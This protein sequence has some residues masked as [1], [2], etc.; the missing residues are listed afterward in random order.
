ML[1]IVTDG[2]LAIDVETDGDYS[3]MLERS[4]VQ[5]RFADDVGRV[6]RTCGRWKAYLE[7]GGK[8]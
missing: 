8:L 4:I 3:T 1:S 5:N 2:S 7:V 6:L